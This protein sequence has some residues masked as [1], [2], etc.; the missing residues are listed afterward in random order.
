MK[1]LIKRIAPSFFWEGGRMW[2]STLRRIALDLTQTFTLAHPYMSWKLFRTV[3]IVRPRYTMIKPPRLGVLWELSRRINYEDIEGAIV[4]CGVWNG[5]SAALMAAAQGKRKLLRD[6]YLFDS[7]QQLPHPVGKDG[8]KAHIMYEEGTLLGGA[9]GEVSK[10]RDAFYHLRLSSEH[11]HI[12]E[13]WFENTFPKTPIPKI[14]LF[15]ID[16]DWYESVKLCLETYYASVVPGGFI[17]FDDYGSWEGCKKAVDE[18]MEAR[19]IHELLRT[20][21][22][23]GYYFRKIKNR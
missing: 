17:V 5:G 11:V 4:E 20:R 16:A 13:G 22:G 12:I 1:R 2:Y 14:A 10:V 23:V 6:I 3:R 8:E 7:F 18:F 19:A 15:H 9:P 21:D